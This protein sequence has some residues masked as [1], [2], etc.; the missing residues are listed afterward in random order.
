MNCLKTVCLA[1]TLSV[2]VAMIAH[3][4]E[5]NKLAAPSPPPAKVA[6]TANTDRPVKIGYVEM[7]KIFSD[8]ERGKAAKAQVKKKTEK[9]RA[10][11][12][13]R[14][15]KLEKMK[16]DI[17]AKLPTLS[18]SQREA[19]VKALQK[20][21]AEFQEFVK[22]AEKDMGKLEGELT[23][24]VMESVEKA[25]AEYGKANGFAAIVPKRDILY[26]GNAVDVKDVT[27]ELT[28]AMSRP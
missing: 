6:K 21:I 18:P 9:Y 25:A 26:L 8:S 14:Q 19:K 13:A 2:S 24:S 3:A 4:E 22:D 10:Q 15:K 16:G 28:K 1:A 5:Q 12:A 17:E 20:K 27:D 11:I 7:E 23:A